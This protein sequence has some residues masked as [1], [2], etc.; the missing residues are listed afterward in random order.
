[1]TPLN[2]LINF[3][4]SSIYSDYILEGDFHEE[5]L[6]EITELILQNLKHEH[7]W[8]TLSDVL[9]MQE[10]KSK[11]LKWKES[12]YTNPGRHLGHYLALVKP[13]GISED[14]PEELNPFVAM[15]DDILKIH[16]CIINYCL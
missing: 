14:D 6:A 16:L 13:Y 11:L 2:N 5:D 4:A 8:E 3:S 15:R 7:A 1:M 10:F 9:T 12:T